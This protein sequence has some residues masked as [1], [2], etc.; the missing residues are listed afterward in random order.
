[1]THRVQGSHD[2]NFATG[3]MTEESE[4][5]SRWGPYNSLFYSGQVDRDSG[6]GIATR[7]G[8][9]SPGIAFRSGRDFPRPSR[10]ALGRTQLPHTLGTGSLSRV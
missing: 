6:V 3:Y 9:Y 1:M 2:T 8:L 10:A 5:D 7:Y 4:L